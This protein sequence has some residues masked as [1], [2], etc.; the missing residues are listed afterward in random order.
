M[1]SVCGFAHVTH[2]TLMSRVLLTLWSVRFHSAKWSF[3]WKL[4]QGIMVC[5]PIV[6]TNGNIVLNLKYTEGAKT[7][8]THFKKGRKKLLIL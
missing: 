4:S 3:D 5:E 8:Y 2:A 1:L 7:I 6:I